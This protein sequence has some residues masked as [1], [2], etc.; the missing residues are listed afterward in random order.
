MRQGMTKAAETTASVYNENANALWA[1]GYFP[2]PIGPGTQAPHRYTPSEKAYELMFGWTER[3]APITTPQPGAGIGVRCGG[4]LVA[5]DYDDDDAALR[6][7]E[8]FPPSPVNKEG[9][10][11]FTAFYRTA[12][13]ISS[14]DF[15]DESG[16]LVVQVLA[17]GKQ[18]VLPP[19]I[20]P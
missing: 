2:L 12:H 6:I 19:S 10:R 1:N 14:E 8:C 5:I 7:S 20:H 15:V 17:T 9:S 18:T 16:V 3:P 13:K 4:G 11:G